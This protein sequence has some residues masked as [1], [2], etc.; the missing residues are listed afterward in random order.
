ML[1]ELKLPKDLKQIVFSYLDI[2]LSFDVGIKNLGYV[3]VCDSA[4]WD[5]GIINISTFERIKCN[6]F[7][8]N[9]RLCG[10]NATHI[11][12]GM[13]H[14]RNHMKHLDRPKKLPKQ[15]E[16]INK[17]KL[18]MIKILDTYKH[19][20]LVNKVYIELQPV[21]KN[22]TMKSVASNL[23]AYFLIR[24]VVDSKISMV[25][26]ISAR[27]KIKLNKEQKGGCKTKKDEYNLR[28]QLSV[29]KAEEI[30]K[31]NKLIYIKY[32]KYKKKDDICDALNQIPNFY[33]MMT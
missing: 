22:P 20:L 2:I 15:K 9:K 10:L 25:K 28:K 5:L 23:Q 16:D 33:D 14:C 32:S 1:D 17:L 31:K 21:L 11:K 30:I 18:N 12:N 6:Y 3:V 27:N 13:T 24:G 19:F 4:I 8:R 26:L 29:D 7:T